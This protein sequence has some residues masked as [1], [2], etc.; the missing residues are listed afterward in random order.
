MSTQTLSRP[1]AA[2]GRSSQEHARRLLH[3]GAFTI[4]GAVVPIGLW[5]GLAPLSMAVVAP[6]FVKVD[7]NRRPVQH[8]EGGIVRTVL[9]RDGQRVNAGDAV[10]VLGDVGVDAERNRLTYRGHVEQAGI[11]RLDAEQARAPSIR[12]PA[13]L[14]AAARRDSRVQEAIAKE[15]SLFRARRDGLVSETALLATQRE[16]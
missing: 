1:S 10:L 16:R 15:E 2:P 7:L 5:M 12:F 8:L 11:A 3:A 4:L 14:V 13:A 9:V 6:A